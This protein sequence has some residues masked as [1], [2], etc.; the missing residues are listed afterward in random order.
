MSRGNSSAGSDEE[1]AKRIMSN[2][3]DPGGGK[4]EKSPY[5]AGFGPRGGKHSDVKGKAK[6]PGGGPIN[7]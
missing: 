7:G 5:R 1:R 6:S 4:S 2:T 3:Q